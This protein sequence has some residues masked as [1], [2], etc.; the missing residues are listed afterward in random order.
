MTQP[1]DGLGQTVPRPRR[2]SASAARIAA[3]SVEAFS[4]ISVA[5]GRPASIVIRRAP[6]DELAE[7]LGLAEIT[8]DRGKADIGD[9]VER[10]QCLHD[11]LADHV[12]RDVGFAGALELAHQR[13]DDALDPVGLDRA[14]TQRDVDRAGQL[15]AVEGLALRGL[16][17]HC[18]LTQLHPLEGR[19]AGA[20]TDAE[21]AT[22]DRAA[23]L[24]RPRILDLGVIG[25][26]ER[27]A[28]FLLLIPLPPCPGP[29]L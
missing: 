8:V 28:P 24:G 16:L 10:R 7:I 20:A 2:A 22:P 14:L 19:E 29:S 18:Q 9:L 25:A 6:P 27:T 21:P 4:G 23:I 26:A 5:G 12:A 17:D 1:T 13:I 3:R 11:Q 15:I